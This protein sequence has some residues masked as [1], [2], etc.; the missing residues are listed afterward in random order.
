MQRELE[1]AIMRPGRD[2]ANGLRNQDKD[3]ATRER[4]MGIL[5]SASLLVPPET[6][7]QSTLSDTSAVL[8]HVDPAVSALK[9]I[10]TYSKDIPPFHADVTEPHSWWL[11]FSKH[12][13]SKGYNDIE[14]HMLFQDLMNKDADSIAWVDSRVPRP[15]TLSVLRDV[16]LSRFMSYN[17]RHRARTA[18]S[19]VPFL[20]GETILDFNNKFSRAMTFA[21]IPMDST[22][23]AH[24][25]Y[26]DFYYRQLPNDLQTLIG[27]LDPESC[28]SVFEISQLAA[29]HSSYR[30]SRAN[31]YKESTGA[32]R[33]SHQNAKKRS[34]PIDTDSPSRTYCPFHKRPTTHISQECSLNPRNQR[35]R[36]SKHP[37]DQKTCFTCKLPW[38]PS[39]R[40]QKR[41]DV[42]YISEQVAK[43]S[44]SD[45]DMEYNEESIWLATPA[46]SSSSVP[47]I[48]QPVLLISLSVS[49]KALA[50]VDSG[51]S[52][53]LIS[54]ALAEHLQV[55]LIPDD[56]V[57]TLANGSTHVDSYSCSLGIRHG[58]SVV[59]SFC[60]RVMPL[61]DTVNVLIGRDLMTILGISIHGLQPLF[62]VDKLERP[63]APLKGDEAI[64]KLDNVSH[65]D[66]CS[67][68]MVNKVDHSLYSTYLLTFSTFIHE[69]LSNLLSQNYSITGFCNLPNAIVSLPTGTALPVYVKQYPM[70]QA[71]HRH[72][73]EQIVKWLSD[74]V[75]RRNA[76]PSAWNNPVLVQPKKDVSGT[77]TGQRVCI[78]PRQVNALLPS[79]NFPLPLIRDILEALSGSKVFSKLDL[80][81]GFH[82]FMVHPE[83]QL[84]TS[85]TWSVRSYRFVGVPFGLKPIPAVF[86]FVIQSLFRDLPYVKVFVDDIIVHSRSFYDH[87]EHLSEVVSRL[88]SANLRLHPD[89]MELAIIELTVLGYHVGSHGISIAKEKL[90]S[91]EHL[92]SPTTGKELQSHLGFF[93]Y[94]RSLIPGYAT[95]CAPLDQ[96][97]NQ[98]SL[99]GLWNDA[100][101]LIYTKIHESLLSDLI[102]SFPDFSVP[103]TLATDASKVGL[104]AVLYQEEPLSL[105]KRYI[106]FASRALTGPAANYDANR[107]ELEGIVFGLEHFR[108]Y[109]WGRHFTLL[110][111]H[112]SLTHMLSQKNL[113]NVLST[114]MEVLLEFDFT[115]RYLP[116]VANILPDRLSYYG[117]SSS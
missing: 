25:L 71:K 26:K 27:F 75:I 18:I 103:F 78:D 36:G 70:P 87:Q 86:Q 28:S 88:T 58:S 54:P 96:L 83:D 81:S 3:I 45:R 99:K 77:I 29:R 37:G 73:D 101:D 107:R 13:R 23:P 40:C 32:S 82:Q 47:P 57:I 49:A 66:V 12:V 8:T 2:R 38:N 52:I 43:V 62:P 98:K 94:F 16:F 100:H 56:T 114:R 9:K 15:V 30:A 79:V 10:A 64:C 4:L 6:S 90:L 14:I 108:Y 69:Q 46:D 42:H 21:G 59:D 41:P 80:K 109:L 7:G 50:V 110:T 51:A 84:K 31:D 105:K 76:S 95:L 92:S 85:F 5:R 115:I 48:R 19:D 113:K 34:A 116:G 97:R 67:F 111:D 44:L 33:A 72:V 106:G 35:D 39:H 65:S 24:A 53:S 20:P 112:S 68:L 22:L 1:L 61:A 11:V 102:L 74:G 89:K 63:L 104:G 93:N 60:F 17:W 91:F 55:Q 117:S